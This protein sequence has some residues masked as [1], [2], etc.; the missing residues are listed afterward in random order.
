M[1]EPEL[2]PC[3]FCGAKAEYYEIYRLWGVYCKEC[4]AVVSFVNNETK[5]KARKA[6]NSRT[7]YDKE[8]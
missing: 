5:R 8:D 7:E 4:G 2:K 1:S 3:P 6:W